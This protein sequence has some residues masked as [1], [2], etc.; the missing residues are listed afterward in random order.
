MEIKNQ[1]VAFDG[2]QLPILVMLELLIVLLAIDPLLFRSVLKVV[3]VLIVSKHM[4]Y[5]AHQG[6]C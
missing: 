3:P 2:G 5:F 4:M 6:H 1:L